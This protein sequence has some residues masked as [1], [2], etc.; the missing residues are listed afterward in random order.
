MASWDGEGDVVG[1]RSSD[2]LRAVTVPEPGMLGLMGAG[3]VLLAMASARGR[4][5]AF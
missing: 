3:L 2:P 1:L 5:G 4:L